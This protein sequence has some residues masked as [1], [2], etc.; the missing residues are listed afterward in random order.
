MFDLLLRDCM[1]F[2]INNAGR[3]LLDVV[4]VI[5]HQ[6]LDFRLGRTERLDTIRLDIVFA[7]TFGVHA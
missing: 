1:P 5:D 7:H 2:H 6:F 3:A 4:I